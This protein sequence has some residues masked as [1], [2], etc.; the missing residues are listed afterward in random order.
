MEGSQQIEV[1][2][3]VEEQRRELTLT[4]G[5]NSFKKLEEEFQKLV[6][7]VKISLSQ[8]ELESSSQGLE[9]STPPDSQP[10]GKKSSPTHVLQRYSTKWEVYVD[11]TE[12]SQ[13]CNGD[14]LTIL[15]RKEHR[16]ASIMC[17]RIY[18]TR[19]Y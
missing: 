7:D 1:L 10:Q 18:N 17:Y 4:T 9:D 19:I 3:V 5:C 14:K 2:L 6:P 8:C 11:V 12:H 16:K 15:R 13:M